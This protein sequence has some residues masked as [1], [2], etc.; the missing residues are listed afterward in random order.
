MRLLGHKLHR[1]LGIAPAYDQRIWFSVKQQVL[2]TILAGLVLDMGQTARAMAAVMAGYWIGA[3]VIVMRRP[4][5]PSKG[6]LL[7]VRWGCSLL[8]AG[9][10][11]GY[12][13]W[14]GLS[15]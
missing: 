4:L 12:L 3:A 5:S 6:D 2:L 1:K 8:A 14:T 7:F 10:L 9:F 15:R 13:I 11:A